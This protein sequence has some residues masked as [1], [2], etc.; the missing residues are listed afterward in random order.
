MSN[1][2]K[3]LAE[4]TI[5]GLLGNQVLLGDELRVERV[6]AEAFRVAF[7]EAP[8]WFRPE[9]LLAEYDPMMLQMLM[10]SV[11]WET[12]G[13]LP[14]VGYTS[15]ENQRLRT[16]ERSR[17]FYRFDPLCKRVVNMWTDYGFGETLSVEVEDP[18]AKEIWDA[19][20]GNPRNRRL[21]HDR[22]LHEQSNTLLTD[23]E[24]YWT[25][26]VAKPDGEVIMRRVPTEQITERITLEN[27]PDTPLFYKRSFVV[28]MK[29]ETLYYPD[30][31]ATK[32]GM[33]D[34]AKLP[35]NA[36]RAD[37][38]QE[39]T[40]VVM[41][42]LT[43]D[44]DAAGRGWPLLTTVNE[45][46]SGYRQFIHDRQAVA[47]SRALVTE[48][49]IVKGGSRAVAAMRTN[50]ASDL[51]TGW[52]R[53]PPPGAASTD[54]HNEAMEVRRLPL[55]TGASDAQIDGATMAAYAG[56]GAGI[57]AGYLGRPDVFQNRAVALAVMAPTIR[58]WQRYQTL[59][60]S[61]VQDWFDVVLDQHEK[62]AI[63]G[64]R[65]ENRAIAVQM[66]NPAETPLEEVSLTLDMALTQGI[67]RRKEAAMVI[68]NRPEFG[69]GNVDAILDEMFPK[70]EEA[71]EAELTEVVML[72]KELFTEARKG[73]ETDDQ[74]LAAE[75][76]LQVLEDMNK[77]G[78]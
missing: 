55:T 73:A 33:L 5:K 68:L 7:Q 24:I 12:Y 36:K 27:D 48:E 29:I 8:W 40:G 69:L 39:G 16:I 32:Q 54:I 56:L 61:V 78:G 3:Q 72:L 63:R 23:G 25:F 50:I 41:M 9:A 67:I 47:R 42:P 6:Q 38:Q 20:R 26:F 4:R 59:W 62:Y 11:N 76:G 34:R 58:Q 43:F 44:R 10:D 77:P 1:P 46:A 35:A 18:R 70:E 30:W 65:I 13:G 71:Q 19:F 2:L 75:L 22:N 64:A 52:D 49:R 21:L 45:A 31:M 60:K 37:K 57:D 17:W 74:K 15:T 53:H 28:D 51:S 14:S 66:D